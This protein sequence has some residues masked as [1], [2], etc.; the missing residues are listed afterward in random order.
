M[1]TKLKTY[2]VHVIPARPACT[3]SGNWLTIYANTKADAVKAARRQVW[4]SC[5][6]DRLDGR[7]I[8]TATEQKDA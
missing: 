2:E 7:L 1:I 3:D 6:Y 5:L 4:N 8:Y